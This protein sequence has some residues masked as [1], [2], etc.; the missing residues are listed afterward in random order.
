VIGSISEAC[1]SRKTPKELGKHPSWWLCS[2]N[3]LWH[4][5]I[6][7]GVEA[8]QNIYTFRKLFF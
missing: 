7:E 2:R 8:Q 5:S 4:I 1:I 3:A 6:L